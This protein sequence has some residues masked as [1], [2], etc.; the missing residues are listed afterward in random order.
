MIRTLAK[1]IREYKK[2]SILAPV[3]VTGEVVMECIIPFIIANLVN[4][5]KAGIALPTL[6]GYGGVL[7]LMA[8]LSLAFGALAGK[9]LLHRQ[10]RFWPQ[11]A[12]GHVLQ[13]PGLLL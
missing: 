1:S 4:E 2:P 11:P 10:L 9:R 12:Q 8:G 3:F 7:V 6:L 13:D 5:I